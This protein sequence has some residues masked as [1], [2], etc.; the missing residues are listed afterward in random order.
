MICSNFSYSV[1]LFHEGYSS[2][3]FGVPCSSDLGAMT[4]E[5]SCSGFS[6][7]QLS[8][9]EAPASQDLFVCSLKISLEDYYRQF[10]NFFVES[11]FVKAAKDLANEVMRYVLFFRSAAN[12]FLCSGNVLQANLGMFNL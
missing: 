12:A 10:K 1:N 8:V 7:I 2:W 3:S 6:E 11:P 9:T 5:S 4:F